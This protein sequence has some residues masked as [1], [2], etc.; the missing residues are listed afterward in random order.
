MND[1]PTPA[2]AQ[3]MRE[4]G[5]AVRLLYARRQPSLARSM[6]L[7]LARRST[8]FVRADDPLHTWEPLAQTDRG[9][10]R[11]RCLQRLM[12][13]DAWQESEADHDEA[14]DPDLPSPDTTTGYLFVTLMNLAV[15]R[16]PLSA[17]AHVFRLWY[18]ASRATL[19]PAEARRVFGRDLGRL[20]PQQQLAVGARMLDRVDERMA[21]RPL[22][23]QPQAA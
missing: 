12:R 23:L 11:A 5:T 9:L 21:R 22:S 15:T 4:L 3:L 13:W 6:A 7:R 1:A 2:P 17:E 14:L 19:P 20:P 18:L 10:G 8:V 16:T